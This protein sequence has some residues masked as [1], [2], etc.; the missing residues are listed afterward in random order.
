MQQCAYLSRGRIAQQ[1][2]F[3]LALDSCSF[4]NPFFSLSLL[5]ALWRVRQVQGLDEGPRKQSSFSPRD[6]FSLHATS[7]SF[8]LGL[9]IV[10][11]GEMVSDRSI[12]PLQMMVQKEIR[13]SSRCCSLLSR[14]AG[15]DTLINTRL[16]HESS[17]DA[18]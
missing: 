17:F 2:S 9:V 12:I 3:I 5:V 7:L 10:D 4:L 1:A 15:V 8:L 13:I 14:T 18:V 16:V 6:V 11:V